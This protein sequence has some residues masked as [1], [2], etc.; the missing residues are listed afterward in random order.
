[1]QKWVRF[2]P[3]LLLVPA[4]LVAHEQNNTKAKPKVIIFAING[5][6]WDVLRPLLLE[7]KMPNLQHV[8]ENGSYGKLRTISA[9]NCPKVFTAFA[10]SVPPEESG[11]SGF[12]VGGQTANT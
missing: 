9:P 2:L 1:M 6:E 8:I 11:I 3:A 7:G 5:A 12:V 10:T 4:L